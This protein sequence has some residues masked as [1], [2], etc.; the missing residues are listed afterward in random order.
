MIIRRYLAKE[1]LITLAALT[2]ILLLIFMSNQFVQYLT[3]SANGSIPGI[4]IF[5]LMMLEIPNLVGLLLPLG[6]YMALLVAYGRLY[7]ESEMIVLQACGYTQ[8]QLISSTMVLAL[9]TAMIAAV[10]TIWARPIIEQDRQLL[11][12]GGGASMLIQAIIPQKFQSLNAEKRLL[13]I[14]EMSRDHKYAEGIFL[15]Q[16][17]EEKGK[18]GKSIW[19]LIWADKGF[20]QEDD[21]NE[22]FIVLEDGRVYKGAPGTGDFQNISFKQYKIRLPQKDSKALV[23]DIRTQPSS[24]LLPFNNSDLTKAA[25]LQWRLSIPLMALTLGLLAVPLSRVDPRRGKF[26]KILPAILVYVVYANMMFV[27]RDWIIAKVV[28]VWLGLWWV[29]GAVLLLAIGLIWSSWRKRR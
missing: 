29:H 10:M 19:T 7:A 23:Y 21:S 13:Y 25:E 8:K 9:G 11:I 5:K 27:G 26:A 20:A 15:A 28:P 17:E 2:S 3:R 1:V 4:I 24:A 14:N 16:R 18:N 22:Q 6:L 12:K